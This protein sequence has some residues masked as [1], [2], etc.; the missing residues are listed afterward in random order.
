LDIERTSAECIAGL[1]AYI[2]R[3]FD[4]LIGKFLGQFRPYCEKIARMQEAGQKGEIGFIHFSVLRTNIL[5]SRHAIR[6][7]A[8]GKEWYADR[9]ECS[10]EYD[11]R[12][13]FSHLY[14][15]ADALEAS[16]NASKGRAKLRDV[17]RAVFEES[18]K[19]LLLI[20]E[21]ARVGLR[22]AKEEQWFQAVKRHELFVV[23]IGDYQDRADILYKEDAT[24]K[25]AREVRRFLESKRQPAY[26]H[27]ICDSLDLANGAYEGICLQF[28]SFDGSDLS[29]SSF[30]NSKIICTSLKRTVLREADFSGAQLFDADFSGATHTRTR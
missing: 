29:G 17:Q 12:E 10:G 8:Y 22:K 1:D 3:N 30:K 14:K 18:N 7:D 2:Q 21:L 20:A 16:M 5:A 15:F 24:A 4:A 28:S 19:Y 13:Y 11:A 26:S 9:T 23:C 6:L 25:D 27:E